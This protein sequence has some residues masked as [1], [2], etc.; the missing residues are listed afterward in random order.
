MRKQ[1]L[2]IAFLLLLLPAS[3][4]SCKTPGKI[5]FQ[6][7]ATTGKWEAFQAEYYR[8]NLTGS[9]VDEMLVRLNTK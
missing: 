1:K 9:E 6:K 3:L 8:E 7:N 4:F 2:F 5:V